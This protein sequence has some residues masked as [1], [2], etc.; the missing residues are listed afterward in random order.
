MEIPIIDG[1]ALGWTSAII[2]AGVR[3]STKNFSEHIMN[4]YEL[5]LTAPLLVQG[6]NGSFISAIPSHEKVL[7]TGWDGIRNG[8]PCL[9]RSW[10]TWKADYDA[11]FMFS[12]APAKTFFH[13]EFEVDALYDAGLV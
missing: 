1:S 2:I 6:E 10:F 9:R 4:R 13:S 12:I 8:A 7:T 5:T 3:S 11:H